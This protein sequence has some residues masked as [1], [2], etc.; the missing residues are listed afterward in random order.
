MRSWHPALPVTAG[1]FPHFSP[2]GE[3]LLA[4]SG[5]VW[6]L[7]VL[8]QRE[9][10][11]GQGWQGGSVW[12][13]GWISPTEAV[14]FT[15]EG[16]AGAYATTVPD[17]TSRRRADLDYLIDTLGEIRD[18]H[19]GAV[20][21]A[22]GHAGERVWYDGRE[23]TAMVLAATGGALPYRAQLSGRYLL[24]TRTDTWDALV[25]DPSGAG[26]VRTVPTPNAADAAFAIGPRGEVVTSRAGRAWL[27]R[28]GAALVEITRTPWAGD[29]AGRLLD[30]A[31]LSWR[32]FWTWHER[33]PGDGASTGSAG[34]GELIGHPLDDANCLVLPCVM[35]TPDVWYGGGEFRA[36]GTTDK[37]LLT[38]LTEIDAT[39][40]RAPVPDLPA[41]PTPVVVA[42]YRPLDG[43]VPLVVEGQLD[44]LEHA[45]A[46]RWLRDGV[47]DQP[48][49]EAI[50]RTRQ[51]SPI[52]AAG[53]YRLQVRAAG[54]GVTCDAK[55]VTTE[56]VVVRARPRD[57]VQWVDA[58]TGLQSGFGY[59]IGAETMRRVAGFS[60]ERCRI[61]LK[62]DRSMSDADKVAMLAAC[63]DEVRAVGLTPLVMIAANEAEAV[64]VRSDVEIYAPTPDYSQ[65]GSE[66]DLRPDVTA[67]SMAAAVAAAMP[68]LRARE[69]RVWTGCASN[70]SINGRAFLSRLFG[71]AAMPADVHLTCHRYSPPRARDNRVAWA[72]FATRAEE[73]AALKA[74]AGPRRRIAITEW[75]YHTAWQPKFGGDVGRW[76]AALWPALFAFRFTDADV[77]R[78]VAQD[79]AEYWAQGV[80]FCCYYQINDGVSGEAIDRFGMRRQPWEQ[81]EW[82]PAAEA[83]VQFVRTRGARVIRDLPE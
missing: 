54:D 46:V 34:G 38:V 82:K 66:P 42:S 64:P 40:Q 48:V 79:L 56:A 47:I 59:P 5:E 83:V 30:V 58:F 68:V 51:Y 74:I 57:P 61:G 71:D 55:P 8:T 27:S 32:W 37:G 65:G 39:A 10:R 15:S 6:L 1:W 2:T 21:S 67:S 73:I 26:Y 81:Q 17:C 60:F 50:E 35:T 7:N 12:A 31:G 23:I 62:P 22:R 18:L 72:P 63:A 53:E 3:W 69:C 25:F 11:L 19:W 33:L 20:W 77:A 13:W 76:L 45:T 44:T 52:T 70:P 9:V 49:R 4:G 36:A 43:P 16:D 24:T 28:V 14:W 41:L 75:G 78:F 29:N 80:T